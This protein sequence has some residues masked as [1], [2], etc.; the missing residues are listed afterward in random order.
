MRLGIVLIFTIF[1]GIFTQIHCQTNTEYQLPQNKK[2][3]PSEAIDSIHGI[4]IYERLN[5]R[6]SWDSVRNCK[7]Y[8]CNGLI[9]DYYLDG[10]VLHKGFY[11]DGQLNNYSNYYPNGTVEREFKLIDDRRSIMNLYY[12]DGTLKSKHKYQDITPTIGKIFIQMEK[13]VT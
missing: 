3:K 1:S 7:G 9:T 4:A 13:Q 6:L 10:S 11:V 5:H 12:P 8:A 2:Y